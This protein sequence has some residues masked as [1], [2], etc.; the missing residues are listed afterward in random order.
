MQ[1][2]ST[3]APTPKAKTPTQWD[4]VIDY[5]ILPNEDPAIVKRRTQFI[6]RM[7]RV[8]LTVA[9]I[10]T[11]SEKLILVTAPQERFE[12]EAQRH[13]IEMK[14]KEGETPRPGGAG[15]AEF[16]I[17]T[18]H[19]FQPHSSTSFFSSLER[20]RLILDIFEGA[21]SE[22]GCGENVDALMPKVFRRFS[23]LHDE[24]D[25][26]KLMKTW[27]KH[28]GR[29][30][31]DSIR[32]Y[33]GEKIA[34]YFAF[35]GHYTVW[36]ISLSIFGLIAQICQF[37]TNDAD[38]P[39]VPFYCLLLSLWTTLYLES[40]KREQVTRAFLWDVQ[41]FEEEEKIRPEYIGDASEGVWVGGYF[42]SKHEAQTIG[43]ETT[44]LS[45]TKHWP[46]W[47]RIL[48][49][50]F[51]VP[52]IGC[53]I[54]STLAGTIGI[55]AFRGVLAMPYPDGYGKTGQII[56]GMVN[57]V[58]I[59]FMNVV[60][61]KVAKWLNDFEN[62]RT[63]TD[64]EDALISKVFLFQFINSY[65]SLFYIAFVKG[66]DMTIFGMNTGHCRRSCLD[67]MS[68]QLF[69]LVVL[70]QIVGNFKELAIPMILGKIKL[71]LAERKKKQ[72]H[73]ELNESAPPPA[74]TKYE[75]ES[76]MEPYSGTFDDYNEM[77]IQFGFVTLFA[78]AFPI[79]SLASL[80]NNIVE[81]RSDGFKLLWQ[82]QRPHY[83]GCEDIG[84]WQGVFTVLS[85]LAVITNV[86]LIGFTSMI[87][88]GKCVFTQD[89]PA[90]CVG[91]H[92]TY[93]EEDAFVPLAHGAEFYGTVVNC[94]ATE[95]K[96][97]CCPV[98]IQNG[99]NIVQEDELTLFMSTFQVLVFVVVVEHALL[100]LRYVLAELIPDV[101]SWVVKAQARIDFNK[102]HSQKEDV[103][104]SLDKAEWSDSPDTIP[105][106]VYQ[107]SPDEYVNK[108]D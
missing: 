28:W 88:S 13:E 41:D 77:A 15:Y 70:M 80:L 49:Y 83:Q 100:F 38:H 93:F 30:P 65:I 64:Y 68:T 104:A 6:K 3:V 25:R 18:K 29:Q 89:F 42:I 4:Y 53:F 16:S 105:T 23:P 57:A 21:K 32:D 74:T 24:T 39:I 67:E 52:V 45:T 103:E 85:T 82:T 55:L 51:S 17:A 9:V 101:P 58:F 12:E 102:S 76:K 94:S 81:I 50:L 59:N 84:S 108:E 27:V 62:Y 98:V 86:C 2:R 75:V 91:V 19:T 7:K 87:L 48:R 54:T 61:K 71:Y 8:G 69:S 56:G 107:P 40:W 44:D 78:A 106:T 26:D 66:R 31:L 90:N 5:P 79:A 34:M 36:L 97:L 46:S 47:K 1:Q 22:R 14:L 60:Y 33:F 43:I 96:N 10:E 72:G 35:L 73:V 95:H 63:D 99:V 11:A 92:C 37:V 20:Q